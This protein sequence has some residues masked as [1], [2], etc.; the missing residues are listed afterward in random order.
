MIPHI[1]FFSVG[2]TSTQTRGRDN[3]HGRLKLAVGLSGVAVLFVVGLLIYKKTLRTLIVMVSPF[4]TQMIP[5]QQ[6]RN[7]VKALIILPSTEHK[8][9]GYKKATRYSR[10]TL[11][12][13]RKSPVCSKTKQRN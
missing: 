13:N 10:T 6:L 7:K 8:R 11:Y 5:S 1:W 12:N 3:R 2:D 4:W 9:W